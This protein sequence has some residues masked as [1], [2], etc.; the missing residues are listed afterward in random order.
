MP[1]DAR[2]LL[3]VLTGRPGSGKSS[4]GRRLSTALRLPLLSRDDVRGGQLATV[5]LWHG[6]IGDAPARETA[7]DA[8]VTIVEGMARLGVTAIVELLVTPG[9]AGAFRRLQQVADVVVIHTEAADAAARAE[10]RDRH[11]PLLARAE[12][13]G[14]LGHDSIDDYLDD[15]ER[16]RIRSASESEP[17]LDVPLL[18]VRTDEGYDPP[19]NDI[20]E[21]IL[22]RRRPPGRASTM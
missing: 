2:P 12:V 7:L 19:I 11:D 14:A 9:R 17:E 8:F 3:V 21:W 22:V 1:V 20:V 10:Q 4:L 15:P 5:G 13:L 6:R 18:R 16:A